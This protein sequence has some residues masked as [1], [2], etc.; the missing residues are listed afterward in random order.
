MAVGASSDDQVVSDKDA[1]LH[2]TVQGPVRTSVD[3]VARTIFNPDE[4]D[5]RVLPVRHDPARAHLLW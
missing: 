4:N 5:E 2:L 3:S 1:V